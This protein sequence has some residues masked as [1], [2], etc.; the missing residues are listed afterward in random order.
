MPE[1]KFLYCRKARQMLEM[2]KQEVLQLEP[3]WRV[4]ELVSFPIHFLWRSHLNTVFEV[5]ELTHVCDI[6]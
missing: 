1:Q 3:R 2:I 5:T 6:S 4:V